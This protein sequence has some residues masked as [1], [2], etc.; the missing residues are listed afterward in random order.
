MYFDQIF[1]LFLD[2]FGRY[3]S[4]GLE[5]KIK[6]KNTLVNRTKFRYDHKYFRK[7]TGLGGADR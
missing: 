2:F 6:T 1:Y 3:N 4:G 7:S 5:R